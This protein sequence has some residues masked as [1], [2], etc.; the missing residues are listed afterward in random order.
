MRLL[1]LWRKRLSILIVLK[2]NNMDRWQS[3]ISPQLKEKLGLKNRLECVKV[4]FEAQRQLQARIDR[5]GG[6]LTDLTLIP[7]LY[8]EYKALAVRRR[9]CSDTR[10][11]N[12]KQFLIVLLM[13]YCPEAIFGGKIRRDFRDMVASALNVK[14]HIVYSM[15]DR[16]AVWYRNYPG[17]REEVDIAY[18]ELCGMG[19]D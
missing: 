7:R 19:M 1:I 18:G 6:R 14:G 15:R 4:A 8:E 10:S 13:L 2:M 12:H 9:F 11:H 5:M 17:F 3:G 16:A